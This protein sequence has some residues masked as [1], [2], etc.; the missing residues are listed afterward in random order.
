MTCDVPCA[1][2]RS[3]HC[4]SHFLTSLST[5]WIPNW[6]FQTI[7]DRMSLPMVYLRGYRISTIF[8][9]QP[10]TNWKI[11][12]N[13]MSKC[14]ISYCINYFI[15]RFWSSM[16]Y[17]RDDTEIVTGHHEWLQDITNGY[18]TSRMVTGDQ[19]FTSWNQSRIGKPTETSHQISNLMLHEVFHRTW[20]PI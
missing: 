8:F 3:T 9:M 2:H 4:T 13:F 7:I 10:I 12:R 19:Q 15:A 5:Y 20:S 6:Y 16:V 11:H 17:R 14:Q 1:F 18:N